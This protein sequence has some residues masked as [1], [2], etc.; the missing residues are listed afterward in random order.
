[1]ATTDFPLNHPQAVK[2]WSGDVFK[3]ALKRT[4]ALRFMGMGKKALCQIRNEMKEEGDRVR[5]GLRVQLDGA[6]IQGDGTLEGQEE[7]LEIYHDD[8][9]I[10]QLRHAVRS[11]GKMSEQRV[12]FSV[13]EEARDGLAD[14]WADRFDTAFFNQLTG[15]TDQADT[16][17]TGNQAC[18][19]PT[20]TID[21]HGTRTATSTASISTADVFS[22]AHIDYAIEQAENATYPLH[23]IKMNGK[24]Y[25]VQFVH[26]YSATDMRRNFTAGEWG[27]IQRAVLE[28]GQT[29]NSA[30]FTGALGVYN[31]TIIHSTTRIPAPVANTRRNVFCG[32][33]AAAIAFGKGNS[34]GNKF[35]WV[36]ELF[37]YENQLGVAAGSIWGLKKMVFNSV[38]FSTIVATTYAAAHS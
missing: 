19:A 21:V 9:Y 5:V 38:D 26:S 15:N 11:G 32:A 7:A 28:G 35:S 17:Y 8:V 23:P 34:V 20:N 25:Y 37:D 2:H 31:N 13:R 4:Q 30:L 1:M 27:D 36:E 6:G 3:E 12:P 24:N 14:W 10:D 29:T 16:R 22:V 18:T 33:Q